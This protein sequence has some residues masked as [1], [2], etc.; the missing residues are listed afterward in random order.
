MEKIYY[1]ALNIIF[2]SNY[3]ILKSLKEKFFSYQ[4]AYQN[5]NPFLTTKKYLNNFKKIKPKEEFE[6]L[7]KQK[8]N[9]ILDTENEYPFLLKQI[10][11]PPLG[12]YFKSDLKAEEFFKG[13]FFFSIIGTRKATL[14]GKEAAK[15]FAYEIADLGGKI[16]SGLALGIDSQAHL[17]ALEAKGITIAVLANSLDLVY[18]PTNKSLAER[19]IKNGALISEYPLKTPPLPYHFIARNRIISGLSLGVLVVEASL[20]SGSLI[21]ANL[22]LSQ[23]REVFAL[24]GS[25]FSKQSQ[26]TNQLI[27][28]GA[29][30]ITET[31]DILEELKEQINI[32][33][34][35]NKSN[36]PILKFD[37]ALQEKIFNLLKTQAKPLEAEKIASYLGISIKQAL[38]EL[39]LLEL[40]G[41]LKNIAGR[42]QAVK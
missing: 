13:K 31:K 38:T 34:N 25:I 19:I 28:K 33:F 23:N 16:V 20:K 12:V 42:W 3:N 2:E 29:K 30:L 9:L 11:N 21:T 10:Q 40:N 1:N 24:P 8:I 5:L 37:N 7:Q 32:D 14:Y 6:N 4:K 22:A 27:Q 15:K 17:G 18:P 35:F 39:S 41:L 36:R 26:G